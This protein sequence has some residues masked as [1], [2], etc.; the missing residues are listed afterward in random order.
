LRLPSEVQYVAK[1]LVIIM[2]VTA[3]YASKALSLWMSRKKERA[4]ARA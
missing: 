1:G 4:A 3:G 2:A